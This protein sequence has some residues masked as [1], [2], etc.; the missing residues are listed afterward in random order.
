MKSELLPPGFIAI[1]GREIVTNRDV[2]FLTPVCIDFDAPVYY[3]ESV[4][5]FWMVDKN[6][7]MIDRL[8]KFKK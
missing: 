6:K 8:K 1:T 2:E 4:W 3:D 7:K 5:R